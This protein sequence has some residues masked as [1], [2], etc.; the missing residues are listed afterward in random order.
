MTPKRWSGSRLL[1]YNGFDHDQRVRKW[2]ALDLAIRMA[3][4]PPAE[5][6]P[7]SVCGVPP[8]PA[9]AYHSEDYGSM[10]GHYPVCKSCHM[11]LHN[12]F[13]SPQRWR[14]FVA[15]VGNG[16]KWFERLAVGGG[17]E[18]DPFLS[19]QKPPT[20]NIHPNSSPVPT[21]AAT[22]GSN[23]RQQMHAIRTAFVRA[24]GIRS[25]EMNPDPVGGYKLEHDPAKRQ[26]CLG[27]ARRLRKQYAELL[28]Q[29]GAGRDVLEKMDSN[30]ANRDRG[31]VG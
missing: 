16:S 5:N 4:E 23:L 9:I 21:K 10:S 30:L 25:Q 14:E 31:R 29:N 27:E 13:R 6:F 8:S 20:T 3:L 24:M 18:S 26:Q 2:Q 19:K 17:A 12:R 22:T 11:R 1:T 7:C 28:K 15:T